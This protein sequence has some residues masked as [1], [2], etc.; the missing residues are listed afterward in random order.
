MLPRKRERPESARLV[1]SAARGDET[2][3]DSLFLPETV[4]A[5]LDLLSQ[6]PYGHLAKTPEMVHRFEE[7]LERRYN[8]SDGPYVFEMPHYGILENGEMAEFYGVE[9]SSVP[10]GSI[11]GGMETVPEARQRLLAE[12]ARELAPE[13]VA[14]AQTSFWFEREAWA[15]WGPYN[16]K[17]YVHKNPDETLFRSLNASDSTAMDIGISTSEKRG[18]LNTYEAVPEYTFAVPHEGWQVDAK[19]GYWSELPVS[20]DAKA[21]GFN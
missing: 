9:N 10:S 21:N 8:T 7:V 16:D 15:R 4:R 6:Y 11:R 5:G 13:L 20:S 3:Q 17:V 19:S 2:L 1:Y 18:N 12:T 14:L